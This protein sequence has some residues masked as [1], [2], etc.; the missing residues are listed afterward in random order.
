MTIL[1]NIASNF[2]SSFYITCLFQFQLLFFT[3]TVF[4]GLGL[5]LGLGTLVLT[6]RLALTHM[7]RGPDGSDN[8]QRRDVVVYSL[9]SGDPW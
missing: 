5:G 9:V 2:S 8:T 6:T 1:K 3:E 7:T 4:G